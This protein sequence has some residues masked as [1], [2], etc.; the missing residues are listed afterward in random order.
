MLIVDDHS[1]HYTK[2]VKEALARMNTKLI[3]I[4]GGLTPKAQIM[5]VLYNRPFKHRVRLAT[6]LH[7]LRLYKQK[8]AMYAGGHV[9]AK[10]SKIERHLLVQHLIDAWEDLD[11]S[12]MQ[13]AWHK[14]KIVPKQIQEETNWD[15]DAA[16][17]DMEKICGPF[18]DMSDVAIKS[19][20][21][22]P[23][24]INPWF[25]EYLPRDDNEHNSGTGGAAQEGD[26]NMFASE[27][28]SEQDLP[29]DDYEQNSYSVNGG[30]AQEG[31]EN[32][33]ASET[34]SEQNARTCGQQVQQA[35][36][37]SETDN[38]HMS[39]ESGEGSQSCEEGVDDAS[40]TDGGSTTSEELVPS[41]RLKVPLVL[42]TQLDISEPHS[43][44]NR[45]VVQGTQLDFDGSENDMEEDLNALKV[46]EETDAQEEEF[47]GTFTRTQ[48]RHLQ[49]AI[50]QS[51]LASQPPQTPSSTA[52]Q[53][54]NCSV[55]RSP[56]LA[57]SGTQSSAPSS[58]QSLAAQVI[59]KHLSA[60][61][62]PQRRC[63]TQLSIASF[64]LTS[65]RA[66]EGP[67][68]HVKFHISTNRKH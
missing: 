64:L 8:K 37:D 53:N 33:F 5:D 49:F 45:N 27:T 32:M 4:P 13:N 30:T 26:D 48:R 10:M 23:N 39:E 11:E 50:Q 62:A 67:H 36:F 22:E 41:H 12:L 24:K 16:F 18:G 57:C 2:K 9:E 65:K 56:R 6:D 59:S 3:I 44:E 60:S 46:L 38:V 7:R 54:P 1:A 43:N 15:I 66:S 31:D 42:E 20:V 35:L 55:R 17:A 19:N 34:K 28:E 51:L 29:R 14:C 68:I 58:S 52:K 25:C 40:D 61:K 21:E 63:G 47:S